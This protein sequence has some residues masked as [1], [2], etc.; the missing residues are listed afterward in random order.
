MRQNMKK[1]TL[2]LTFLLSTSAY[3]GDSKDCPARFTDIAKNF[4]NGHADL[5][6]AFALKAHSYRSLDIDNLEFCGAHDLVP[7][8]WNLTREVTLCSKEGDQVKLFTKGELWC[9]DEKVLGISEIVFKAEE[10]IL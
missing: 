8:S 6:D 1:L 4:L 3:S 10:E 2:A 5:V 9:D 7:G